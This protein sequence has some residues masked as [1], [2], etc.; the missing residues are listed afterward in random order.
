MTKID[1]MRLT[2]AQV[3]LT[4]FKN[5][6]KNIKTLLNPQTKIC[7][8]V[9]ANGY[10]NGVV[11]CAKAATEAGASFLAIAAVSE[12]IKIRNAGVK[13]PLLLLSLCCPQE[14][15]QV[16]ENS[17]TPL[18]FD[19]EMVS[20]Y[21]EELEKAGCSSKFPVHMAV[22]TGMGRIGIRPEEAQDIAKAIVSSRHLELGGMCTH[23]AVADSLA[24]EDIDYTKMQ[25]DA[26]MTAIS[27]VEKAGINPGI[28]HCCN[29]PATLNHPEWQLDMVRP[30]IVVYGYYPDQITKEYLE[31]KGTPVEIRP[32]MTLVSGVCAIRHFKKGQSVSYGHTW[33]CEEDTDIAVVPCGYG[34]GFLRRYNQVVTP[35][36]NGKAYPI[37]GRICMDQ[38]MLDIGKD[39]KDVKRWDKVV[40]FGDS[41]A[42]AAVSAQEIADAT[43]TIPYEIMTGIT[44]RVERVFV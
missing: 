1:S 30:G 21:D 33:T 38:F 32:V 12:G 25:Y 29:S 28:R 6:I 9:K 3:N 24:P 26:F 43:G 14:I 22:D 5:N 19:T 31:K 34:D 35:V 10:G 39:N 8:A 18:I 23:F 27:N 11:E 36:I 42:G 44:E 40:L 13:T 2:H 7:V 4:N 41:G 20:L 37:R 15:P 17:I 16:I